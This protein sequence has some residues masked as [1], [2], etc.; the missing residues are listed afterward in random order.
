MYSK[1]VN[2][3]EGGHIVVVKTGVLNEEN[4]LEVNH[5]ALEIFTRNRAS[6]AHP[7]SGAAQAEG[8]G[9]T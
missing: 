8:S 9:T 1:C 2:V 4:A 3:T 6:W 7:I 5:P